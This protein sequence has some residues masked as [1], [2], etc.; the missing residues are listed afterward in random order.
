M[1]NLEGWKSLRG[2]KWFDSLW[3]MPLPQNIIFEMTMFAE[4]LQHNTHAQVHAHVPCST[5]CR[6]YIC[7]RAL[8]DLLS[9]ATNFW[10]VTFIQ[11]HNLLRIYVMSFSSQGFAG[12]V[13]SL[14]G[15]LSFPSLVCAY[16]YYSTLARISFASKDYCLNLFT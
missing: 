8:L 3:C 1:Y 11:I 12:A 10:Q 13:L 15:W 4:S 5:N 16:S 2:V 7:Q 14:E 9:G 6:T